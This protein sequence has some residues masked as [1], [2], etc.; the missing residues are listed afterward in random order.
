MQEPTEPVRNGRKLPS[1]W[2]A[3]KEETELLESPRKDGRF[4][5][6]CLKAGRGEQRGREMKRG[7]EVGRG[8]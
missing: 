2:A 6:H 8:R 4:E 7:G 5:S 3:D 1:P